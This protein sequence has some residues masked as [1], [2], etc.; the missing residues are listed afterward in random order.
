MKR[1]VKFL[2][3]N[4]FIVTMLIAMIPSKSVEAAEIVNPLV[5]IDFAQGAG[6]VVLTGAEIVNDSTRGNVLKLNG[7]GSR[8]SYGTYTT[9]VFANNDWTKGMTLS[10]WIQTT[11]GGNVHGAAPIYCVDMAN[12]GYIATL[13][14]LETTTNTNGNEGALLN[15]FFGMTQQMLEEAQTRP[16]RVSGS[17]LQLYMTL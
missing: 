7:T 13:C 8:T 16:P 6:D 9:D 11:E 2:V 14:S 10:A 12:R 3:A 4:V 1:L 15:H 17:L 5:S